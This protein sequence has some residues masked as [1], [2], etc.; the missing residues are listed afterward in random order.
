[1]IH[2]IL[3]VYTFVGKGK[4]PSGTSLIEYSLETSRRLREVMTPS[5]LVF[6]DKLIN[7]LYKNNENWWKIRVVLPYKIQNK[8]VGSSWYDRNEKLRNNNLAITKFLSQLSLHNASTTPQSETNISEN[9]I[10][11]L[12]W[13][14]CSYCLLRAMFCLQYMLVNPPSIE[15]TAWVYSDIRN[16]MYLDVFY[17]LLSSKCEMLRPRMK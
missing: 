2:K 15:S 4:R 3:Y 11:F 14:L 17:V 7:P 10:Y 5:R 1:M 8:G 13:R 6:L 12:C 9:I 16:T